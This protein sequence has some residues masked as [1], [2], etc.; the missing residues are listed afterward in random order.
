MKMRCSFSAGLAGH[1]V[2]LASMLCS[3][4]GCASL[5][6]GLILWAAAWAASGAA[7][8]QTNST[9]L[10][11][12][13]AQIKS[14]PLDP[15]ECYRV[16][17]FDFTR[18]DAR[19]YLTDGFLIFGKEVNGRR[20]S[21]VFVGEIDG[22]DAEILMFPPLRSERMSLAKFTESPNLSEHFRFAAFLFTD[23]THGEIVRRLA[24][25]YSGRK[26]P[27]AGPLYAEKYSSV[28][29]NLAESL[30]LR[31]VKDI[32]DRP[33]PE[34]GFFFASLRGNRMGNFD[35]V[36]DPMTRK[37][38][39]LG[40]FSVRARQPIFDM[41][42]EFEPRSVTSGKRAP[43]REEYSVDHYSIDA[44]LGPDLMLS[45][46]TR[47]RLTPRNDRKTI[48]ML[49]AQDMQISAARVGDELLE[50]YRPSAMRLNSFRRD[51]DTVFLVRL[52]PNAR[53]GEPLEL[54]IEHA[55]KV[56][57][58]SGNE[59]F[60]VGSRASW[61]PGAGSRFATYDLTFRLPRD[62]DFVATSETAEVSVEGDT[63][64]HRVSV[65][66]PVRTFGFNIG[67]YKT[68]TVKRN[69]FT[70]NVMAN[71]QVETAL[72]PANRVIVVP[73][74]SVPVGRR[75]ATAPTTVT[76]V[77]APR[78]DPTQR[79]REMAG[80]VVSLLESFTTA[81]GPPPVQTIHVSPIPGNF[82][83]GFAGMIYISTIA[84][85][86]EDQRPAYARDNYSKTFYSNLLLAHELSHQWWGNLVFSESDQDEWLMEGLATYSALMVYEEQK[87][88]KAV[89]EVLRRYRD[90]LLA[91]A[92]QGRILEE[93]GPIIWGERLVNSRDRN[94]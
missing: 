24:E 48:A 60:F 89:A 21:A 26:V 90:N 56:I 22:G 41:W 81:L 59:V 19:I 18:E 91:D 49:L 5:R 88:K 11:D 87:G 47:V 25:G 80:E 33:N 43:A 53:I 9:S 55:G 13:A 86:P 63:A 27:E 83:Q 16:R 76:T 64:I 65:T 17:D 45:A 20:F 14:A 32:M 46:L 57:Q 6:I 8:A 54:Q 67:M 62:L 69:G 23:D 68:I 84:Y 72:E 71:K 10:A 70:V 82:G 4:Y 15:D 42:T 77:P 35:F 1:T 52:P 75:P 66:H 92:G 36:M 61:Y 44:T 74:P 3:W 34:E 94:A 31:L 2:P 50:V 7:T 85:L 58:S 93:A 73:S 29:M 37:G 79:L 40:Q 39:R 51:R 78:P 30:E 28:V 12:L 38:I